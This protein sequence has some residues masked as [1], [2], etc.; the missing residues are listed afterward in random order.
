M[1]RLRHIPFQGFP[2]CVSLAVCHASRLPPPSSNRTCGFPASGFHV[3]SR[4]Q[5]VHELRHSF[6]LRAQP[7]S[8]ERAITQPRGLGFRKGTLVQAELPLSYPNMLTFRPLRSTVVTRFPA[9]MGLSDSQSGPLSGLCI[10][11]SRW[12]SSPPPHRA[13]QV[14]RRICPRAP[15][16]S[17]PGSSAAAFAHCFTT[18][19]KLHPKGKTSYSH[20]NPLTR[21]NRF[22][23]AMAHEFAFPGFASRIA[24][25]HAG[26]ATC[27]NRQFT[28]SAPLS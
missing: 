4:P 7:G 24:P 8:Q 10:P 14:P 26:S 19:S 1:V 2:G 25:T 28:W 27:M 12:R 22:A 6:N 23:F 13:S 11:P 21:P 3:N 5:V 15:S 20:L 16:T 18:D 9:T 17:T